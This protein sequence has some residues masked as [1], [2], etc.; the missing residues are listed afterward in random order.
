MIGSRSSIFCGFNYC[1]LARVACWRFEISPL[2]TII[3]S[4]I[5]S[6]SEEATRESTSHPGCSAYHVAL[7]PLAARPR[8]SDTP[9]DGCGKPERRDVL[10]HT[11]GREHKSLQEPLSLRLVQLRPMILAG[12]VTR[13]N[14][15]YDVN[16]HD[17]AALTSLSMAWPLAWR[18]PIAAVIGVWVGSFS[19]SPQELS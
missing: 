5:C 15:A 10:P 13:M 11:G 7:G 12:G 8:A 18:A 2:E 6:A 19:L 16:S 17:C 3:I 4:Q 1:T 14:Q 9:S